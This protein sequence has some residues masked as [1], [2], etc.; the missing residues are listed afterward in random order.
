MIYTGRQNISEEV[1][2]AFEDFF[3][4]Y[5]DIS[6][7]FSLNLIKLDDIYR[8]ISR[9]ANGSPINSEIVLYKWSDIK[10]PLPSFYGLIAGNDLGELYK[11]FG[12]QLF[13]PNIRVHLGET[14]VNDGIKH[15]ISESP[16]LFW[17]FNNGITVL[18]DSIR[19]KPIGGSGNDM[20][21]FECNNLRIVNG[22]QTV[23]TIAKAI[24]DHKENLKKIKVWI[25]I[26]QVPES[27]SDLSKRITRTNNTQNRID[28]RDFVSLD[29]EQQRL[30]D[31]LLLEGVNYVFRSGEINDPDQ[32]GFDLNDATVARACNQTD[33][34]LA[35]QAKREISR[36]WH[37]ID[38]APYRKLF[39]RS[40][41][42]PTLYREVQILRIV[43][44][45]LKHKKTSDNSRERLMATHG[46]RF[47]L[48]LVFQNI[49]KSVITGDSPI[50]EEKI[51]HLCTTYFEKL[52]KTT[53]RLYPEAV[54]GS[55]FKNLTKCRHI[56]SEI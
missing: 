23:G 4:E 17:Y 10:E 18:C 44:K 15:T 2:Q 5:N 22:A 39:N 48:H 50:H 19:K 37:D 29:P 31:E 21:I 49:D 51:I 25:R 32:E 35:V 41:T 24:Q 54:L 40:I 43:E 55:L 30:R 6:P 7:I 28:S 16:E 26:I 33:I 56:K 52:Y 46:N 14:E 20:G 47:L 3:N 53:N 13:S 9:G 1:N 45:F 36:L 38:K 42:G 12:R 11:K 27:E 34:Q 8:F